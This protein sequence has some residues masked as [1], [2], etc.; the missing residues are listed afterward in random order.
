MKGNYK[1]LTEMAAEIE[2]INEVKKDFIVKTPALKMV[3]DNTIIFGENGKDQESFG[4]NDYAHGQIAGRLDIP[5]KFYD[6][7]GRDYPGMR[8]NLVNRLFHEAPVSQRTKDEKESGEIIMAKDRRMVR[9]LDGKIRAFVSDKFRPYDNYHVLGSA[10]PPLLKMKEA[11]NLE[12]KTCILTPIKMYLELTFP[13]LTAEVRVGDVIQAGVIISNSE[14]GAGRVNV[15]G[16]IW[17]LWCKNGATSKSVF[18]RNHVGRKIGGNEDDYQTFQDDTIMSDLNTFRLMLRDILKATISQAWIEKEAGLLRAGTYR[19]I[20]EPEAMVQVVRDRYGILESETKKVFQ[21]LCE[22]KDYTQY[23]LGNA[24]TAL[25]REMDDK[26]RAYEIQKK[27]YQVLT[28]HERSWGSLVK[29]T[30]KKNAED[31]VS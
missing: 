31:A 13:K 24:I 2:R 29:A 5:K 3:D 12:I 9:T 14:V 16:N 7:M 8:T 21:N 18:A 22:E 11:G 17:R 1:S 19:E 23:G 15:E 10:L 25:A 4:I 30:E 27:G 28:L 26:D 20:K 6:R